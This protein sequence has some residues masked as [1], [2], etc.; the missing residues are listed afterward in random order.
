[1]VRAMMI[2]VAVSAGAWAVGGQASQT[3]RS[4]CAPAAPCCVA[5][6]VCCADAG[7]VSL[8]ADK[9]AAK[10]VKVTGTLVCGRCKLKETK[11]CSNVLLVKE[12]G[13]EVKYYL[14]DKGN[15]ESYHEEVCGGGELK[16]VTATGTV[17]E[18]DG[19]KTLKVTKLDVPKK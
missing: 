6:D 16:G 17:S 3:K 13:K 5:G 9:P 10:E 11:A 1:M 19:K 4:C 15:D 2:A 7:F 12:G 18:K 8:L 14:T